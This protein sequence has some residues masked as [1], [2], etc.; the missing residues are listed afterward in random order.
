M[1][2]QVHSSAPFGFCGSAG[3]RGSGADGRSG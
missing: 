1:H 2:W 3:Y